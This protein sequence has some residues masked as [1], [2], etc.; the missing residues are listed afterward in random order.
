M[1]EQYWASTLPSPAAKSAGP[2]HTSRRGVDVRRHSHRSLAWHGGASASGAVVAGPLFSIHRK[3]E[4][5]EGVALG[6]VAAEGA[7]QS[8]GAMWRQ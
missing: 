4:S 7:Q 6:R 3:H 1:T 8:G 5:V 2:T